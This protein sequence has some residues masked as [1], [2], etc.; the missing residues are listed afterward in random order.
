MKPL[1]TFSFV[2][3]FAS[4]IF[5]VS[6]TPGG[7]DKEQQVVNYSTFQEQIDSIL[8]SGGTVTILLQN[9]VAME[10]VADG[11]MPNEV[12]AEDTIPP[13]RCPPWCKIILT[14]PVN[15]ISGPQN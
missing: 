7:S 1:L 15:E 13:R 10:P 3:V 8:G 5:C 9:G 2:L 12:V 6:C 4:L 11:G 14:P